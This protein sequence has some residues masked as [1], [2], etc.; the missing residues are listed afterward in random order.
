[1]LYSDSD[2]SRCWV[3]VT[4]QVSGEA[5]LLPFFGQY[6]WQRSLGL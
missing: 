6:D 3:T 2:L 5:W 1:M 4:M